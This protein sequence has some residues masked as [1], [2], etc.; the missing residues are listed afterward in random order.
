MERLALQQEILLEHEEAE[1][2]KELNHLKSYFVSS[3]SHDMKTPLTAI[4]MF[5]ELLQSKPRSREETREYL[6]II[7]GESDRLTRLINNVL[8]FSTIERGIKQYT[9]SDV[10]LNTTLR[11]A[12]AVMNYQFSSAGFC[13]RQHLHPGDLPVRGDPDALMEAI[14]NVLSNAMKY[15]PDRKEIEITTFLE[16][17]FGGICIRDRGIGIPEK[18]RERIFEPFF[19]SSHERTAGEG[20]GLGLA[21]VKHAID[22]HG[23]S[24]RV[25]SREGEG[26]SFTLLIPSI[27]TSQPDQS[28]NEE[29]PHH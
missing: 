28:S 7:D 29:N 20:I 14:L 19:R 10:D 4:K 15:S 2:L 24:I 5:T 27:N 6:Q 1:R 3:V 25:E 21:V 23:G 22:A 26:S 16:N 12:L 18:G 9:F 8:D 13:I 17:G 11:S